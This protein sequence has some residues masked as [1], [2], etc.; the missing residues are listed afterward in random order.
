MILPHTVLSIVVAGEFNSENSTLINALLND[1]SL[2]SM[3]SPPR[4]T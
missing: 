2:L 1:P 4:I 3:A